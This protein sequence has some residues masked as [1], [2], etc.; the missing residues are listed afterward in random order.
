MNCHTVLPRFSDL[1][2][3]VRCTVVNFQTQP[4]L[5]TKQSRWVT[6]ILLC[7]LIHM[8]KLNSVLFLLPLIYCKLLY[9]SD[10][11]SITVDFCLPAFKTVYFGRR[12]PGSSVGIATGY[13]LDGP[14]IKFRWGV[15]SRTC[16]DRPWGSSTLL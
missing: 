15:I 9:Q 5:Q 1:P 4:Q 10:M 6:S 13:G 12:G 14:G 7:D 3:S 8:N 11:L 16:P 2:E